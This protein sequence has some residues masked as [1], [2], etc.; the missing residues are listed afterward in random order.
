MGRATE[1]N[2][3]NAIK[4]NRPILFWK[5]SLAFEQI[6]ISKGTSLYTCDTRL[7]NP[8]EDYFSL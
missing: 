6:Q 4:T 8:A 5:T 3:L 1:E 7:E 2:G